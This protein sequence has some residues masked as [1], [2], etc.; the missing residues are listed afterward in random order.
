MKY[1]I[2]DGLSD[3]TTRFISDVVKMLNKEKQL[4]NVD[5]S[6]L[7][8]LANAYEIYQAASKRVMVNPVFTNYRG[9]RTPIPEVAI[10][11]TYFA[12]VI[13]AMD[14]LGITLKART[15]GLKKSKD[16][17]SSELDTFFKNR[18]R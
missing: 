10:S 14:T 4:Q 1:T 11:K 18:E 8:M 3:E 16:E 12:Q 7:N 5:V 6:T 2:P 13:V 15:K 9:D 17:G